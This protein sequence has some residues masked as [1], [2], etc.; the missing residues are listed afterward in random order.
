MGARS[1]VEASM[2]IKKKGVF[3]CL[4]V[5]MLGGAAVQ[6]AHAQPGAGNQAGP[7]VPTAAEQLF[8]F[9]NR[10]RAEAGA[11]GL[12]WDEALA[13]AARQHCLRMAAEGPLAHRYGG[14]PDLSER[15]SQAGAHF[16]LIEENIALAPT[17]AEI[18]DGW[19][20]SP[21]HRSNLLNPEVDRVGIAVVASRGELYAVA[22]YARGVR[23]LSP[24]QVEAQVAALIQPSGVTI[25][26]DPGEARAACVLNHGLPASHGGQP[27]QFVMRWQGADLSRLPQLLVEKLASGQYRQASVGSCSA[28][29]GEGVFSAYR[30]AV[31]LY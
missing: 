16:S 12:K 6:A 11:G 29:G 28:R 23:I 9:A 27:A 1:S 15:A 13:E 4:L 7:L 19:M 5:G 20:H 17:P 25:L 2:V 14:E 30:L 21:G 31:L 10:S 3:W 24:A 8:A 26:R 18:H 22:D